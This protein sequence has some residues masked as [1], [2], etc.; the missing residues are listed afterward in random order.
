MSLVYVVIVVLDWLLGTKLRPVPMQ[1]TLGALDQDGEMATT[2]V[3]QEDIDTFATDGVVCMRGV[4]GGEWIDRL[5]AGVTAT[6]ADP[7]PR[8]RLWNTDEHGRESRYDSQVWKSRPEYED[9]IFNS[10]LAGIAGELMQSTRV[11]FYFDAMFVRMP[12]VQF[13][14]PF[15]QDEPYWSIEGF[16]AISSWMP[17]VPVAKESCLE[18]VRGS[19]LWNENYQQENFGAMVGDER[20]MVDF[21]D[22]AIP[23]PDIEGERDRYDIASWDMEPGDVICFNARCVHGGSGNL[24]PDRELRV[25]N[26]KWTGDDVRV[27]FRETGMD[28]DHSAA[29]TEV[30]LKPG[31]R[32]GTYLYPEVWTSA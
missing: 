7:S 16:Q 27:K 29:M 13:R 12:G 14:T 21:G 31:D 8:S 11:N 22:D 19:H 15:H 30:G 32:L 20:D 5:S 1:H 3:T 24:A 28:P 18:I 25:F 17:L 9:F 26:T 23:F 4:I 6:L 2:S 10:P